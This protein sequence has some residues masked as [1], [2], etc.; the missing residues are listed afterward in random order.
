[1]GRPSVTWHA[2]PAGQE[3]WAQEV[4]GTFL[5]IRRHLGHPPTT[6]Q[7]RGVGQRSSAQEGT[8]RQRGHPLRTLQVVPARHRRFL[9]E[10]RETQV[11]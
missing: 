8:R 5:V 11:G 10:G 2:A 7:L 1:M 6:R 3:R 4:T 9:Q